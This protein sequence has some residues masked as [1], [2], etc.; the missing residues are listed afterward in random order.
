L[1][2]FRGLITRPDRTAMIF[3]SAVPCRYSMSPVPFNLGSGP[4]GE[5]LWIL[6]ASARLS[7]YPYPGKMPVFQCPD[8]KPSGHHVSLHVI[9]GNPMESKRDAYVGAACKIIREICLHRQHR[10]VFI[11]TDKGKIAALAGMFRDLR[12]PQR[13]T[14]VFVNNHFEGCA[15]LTIKRIQERL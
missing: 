6:N 9:A 12:K 4:A 5:K 14:W 15:P 11:A 2:G 10:A 1:G 13:N 3:L 7:P 8:L